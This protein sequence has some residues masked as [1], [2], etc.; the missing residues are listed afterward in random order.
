MNEASKGALLIVDDEPL[1][2]VT[3]QIELTEAGYT[4]YE[5]ASPHAGLEQLRSHP[6]DVVVTDLRMP[7]MDGLQFLDR[8]RSEWPGMHVILMTAY[9]SVD[10]AV[11]AMKRGAYDYISK[12]FRTETLIEKLDR[13]GHCLKAGDGDAT[14]TS[15]LGKVATQ[16]PLMRSIFD[17]IHRLIGHESLILI[18]GEVG[19]EKQRIA[20]AIHQ[21]GARADRKLVCFS[22]SASNPNTL[23]EELFGVGSPSPAVAP[24]KG[25]LEHADGGTIILDDIDALPV[26]TQAKLLRF[27]ETGQFE[28]VG[29][30]DT[31]SAD[32]HMICT[33]DKDL[34]G[35]VRD[36]R[37]REDLCYRLTA[38][39]ISLPPLRDRREDV[40]LLAQEF[41]REVAANG[42]NN[43]PQRIH[44]Y[45]LERLSTYHWPGNVREL[46]HVLQRAVAVA[47][48]EEICVE[49]VFLPE[50]AP[51]PMGDGQPAEDVLAGL[52]E[53]VAGVERTMIDAALR[54]AA[55]N[56]AKAAQFLGIPRTTL[57]DKMTKYGM[58]GPGE[59]RAS[60]ERS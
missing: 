19:T 18:R 1:K 20:E 25:R 49:D 21:L 27:I 34:P 22:C 3:L 46:E 53:T 32:V 30:A 7:E 37:F 60:R 59:K 6:V 16:S 55:G 2:R 14:T 39:N 58:V 51:S 54:R 11:E 43:V 5:A 8:V 40:P 12:P 44:P 17:A 26:E 47:K 38:V 42:D 57:R 41:L 52:T 33:T 23:E 10:S 28:R 50:S 48:G 45:A 13:L 15:R 36:G 4:V 29:Q 9:G 35:L 56:Q 24:R 31:I